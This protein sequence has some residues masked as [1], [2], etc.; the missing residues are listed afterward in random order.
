VTIKIK[1]KLG[2]PE[3]KIRMEKLICDLSEKHSDLVKKVNK[4]WDAYHADLAAIVKGISVA[5]SIEIKDQEVLLNFGIPLVAIMFK[6]QIE[7]EIRSYLQKV[8]E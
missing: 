6:K 8:L 1:H 7:T 5:G 4:K 2:Q 3:S